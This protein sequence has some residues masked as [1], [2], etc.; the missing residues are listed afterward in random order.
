MHVGI[1]RFVSATLALMFLPGEPAAERV[2][3]RQMRH[4]RVALPL[5]SANDNRRSAG[6]L[7]GDTL[8][9]HLDIRM[10]RWYPEASDGPFI[11]TPILGE[12]GRAPSVPGPLIRVR[13]GTIIDARITNALA[14][15]SITWIGFATRPGADSLVV[16]PGATVHRTFVAGAPGTYLYSV[17]V[18]TID[19][20]KDEREQTGA[21]FVID[22]RG[23]RT[24]DRIFVMNIWGRYVDSVTFQNALT[25]NGRAW[26][27]NERATAV[28]GDTVR[29]RIVNASQRDHP[30]HLH[31]FFYKVLSRGSLT[32]DSAFAPGA[33]ESVVTETM[34]PFS[35]M[36][37]SWVAER[38]GNWLFHCHLSFHVSA[39][40]RF[41]PGVGHADH[42]S[43]DMA[44]HMAG[45]VLGVNVM[46]TAVTS[47]EP[48]LRPRRLRLAVEET[49]RRA[50][51]ARALSFVLQGEGSS[52]TAPAKLPGT[53]LFLT[54]GQ[55]TD[56]TVLNRL[57]EATAVHWHGIELESYSDGVAGWSGSATRLAPPIAPADSFTAHLTLRRAGTFMYH[58]HLNDVEQLTSGLYGAIVVLKRG[59][60]FTPRTD[61]LFVVGWDGPEDPPHLVVNGDSAPPPLILAASVHHRLR[62]IFIGVVGGDTFR[63]RKDG[64]PVQWRPLARDGFDLPPARRIATS[65]EIMG[66][67]GQTFDYDFLPPSTGVYT[68][69]AGRL[70]SPLWQRTIVVR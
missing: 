23:A 43:G 8:V 67:A 41:T 46:P 17:R 45:L 15:S 48:R 60:R 49:P 38:D 53:T 26:P 69:T 20:A 3:G 61:H 21:A 5:V 57:G 32:D 37:M 51:A 30:M 70:A 59:Q 27:Y 39:D 47:R 11:E 68:L 65:A 36:A 56:I 62:F 34:P 50:R 35:T 42:T 13:E 66:W 55:P 7:H 29:W 52:P 22:A 24:D 28:R 1:G 2:V 19:W 58:T 14:D 63:L 64:H 16:T 12:V 54:R 33:A 4:A 18:G 10:A 44:R 25:I 31:G 6:A 40:A 9:V